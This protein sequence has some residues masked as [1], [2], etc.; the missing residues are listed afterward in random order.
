MK[1]EP[2]DLQS[3]PFDRS[4]TSPPVSCPACQGSP[5]PCPK[6]LAA[7]PSRRARD[8]AAVAAKECIRIG[9]PVPAHCTCLLAH[10]ARTGNAQ[11]SRVILVIGSSFQ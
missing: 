9:R 5:V 10:S 2:S 1:A 8:L 6:G 11:C 4:G 7:D 3:D